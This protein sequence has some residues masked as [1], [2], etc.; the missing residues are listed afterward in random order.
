MASSIYLINNYNERLLIKKVNSII[1][2]VLVNTESQYT[3]N[4]FIKKFNF[5]FSH[6]FLI[7]FLKIIWRGKA[8]RVRFFK[9]SLKFTF[10]F[11]HSH[12]C[13][14]LFNSTI[15]SFYR[16][17]RQLYFVTFCDRQYKNILIKFFNTIRIYNK[18]TKRG[19]RIKTTPYKR[20]F[21]KISQHM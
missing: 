7:F 1:A 10:N 13:K 14:L 15:Y 12:W 21:G 19:I 18:Y 17:K 16:F 11:G 6:T 9:K 3:T 8:Y 2:C 4:R 5:Y 20:R